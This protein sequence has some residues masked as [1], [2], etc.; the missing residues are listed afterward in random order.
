MQSVANNQPTVDVTKAP[1]T[2]A[3][4]DEV[5]AES[6]RFFWQEEWERH[7]EVLWAA[8]THAY[9]LFN[10]API[11]GLHSP[12]PGC[13]KT[14]KLVF[15][16]WLVRDGVV[17][18]DPTAATLYREIEA[19]HPTLLL[20]EMDKAH[21]PSIQKIIN[22][23]FR[24]GVTVPRCVG[25]EYEVARFSP[26]GPKALAT[27]GRELPGDTGDRTL[28]VRM[29]MKPRGVKLEGLIDTQHEKPLRALGKKL[30]AWVKA[31]RD[32]LGKSTPTMPEEVGRRVAGAGQG[33]CPGS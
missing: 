11:L 8:Y 5:L 16:S 28:M 19:R 30:A 25:E 24:R 15:L 17:E 20:D 7:M 31:V 14:D 26:F 3:V 29:R 12:V 1:A 4:L 6:Q 21:W 33:G 23:G 32:A 27:M 9:D 22:S 13:A 2:A 18:A 10:H